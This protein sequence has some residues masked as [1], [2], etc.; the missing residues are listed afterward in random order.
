M[1]SSKNCLKMTSSKSCLKLSL[2]YW[3]MILLSVVEHYPVSS[4]SFSYVN[5]ANIWV[6]ENG[7]TFSVNK[8]ECVHFTNQ[9]CVFTELDIKLDGT[10]SKWQMK[11]AFRASVRPLAYFQGPRDT[12]EDRLLS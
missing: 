9:R 1:T 11:P 10:S 7:I 2:L 6:Q 8:T 4:D 12:P 5:S 3:L